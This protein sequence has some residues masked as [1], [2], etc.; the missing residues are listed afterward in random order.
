MNNKRYYNLHH[1]IF[2]KVST[3][4]CKQVMDNASVPFVLIDDVDFFF[5]SCSSSIVSPPYL[6]IGVLN[7]QIG[8]DQNGIHAN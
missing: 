2:W 8:S 6:I 4:G 7:G 1:Y 3:Y 5:V